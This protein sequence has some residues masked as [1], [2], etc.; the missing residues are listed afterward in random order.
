MA[1]FLSIII[2]NL[3]LGIF[4]SNFLPW[5]FI[6][7]T[8]FLIGMIQGRGLWSTF[9]GG[10]LAISLSWLGYTAYLE[11]LSQGRLT[12][13]VALIFGLSN[14]LQLMLITIILGGIVS[15]LASSSGYLL[16][17]IFYVPRI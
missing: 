9:V 11:T 10:F 7:V 14:S 4:L 3:L 1:V 12:S 13:K 2:I 16:K 8:A 15:G 17:R 5:W 6:A